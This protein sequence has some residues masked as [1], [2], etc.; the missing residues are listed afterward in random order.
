MNKKDLVIALGASTVTRSEI[1]LYWSPPVDLKAVK[2]E[3]YELQWKLWSRNWRD[4][5][6]LDEGQ[7]PC[8]MSS[9]ER[10]LRRHDWY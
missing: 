8:S 1:D 9:P 5:D 3:R 7:Y 6:L 4:I 2:A 10:S